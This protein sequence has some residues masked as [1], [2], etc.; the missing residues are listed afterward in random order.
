MTRETVTTG[1]SSVYYHV[2]L[3]RFSSKYTHTHAHNTYAQNILT[4]KT[5]THAQNTHA[6]NT[7]AHDTNA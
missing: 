6:Q 4:H 2:I 3:L 5:H 1:H 7:H